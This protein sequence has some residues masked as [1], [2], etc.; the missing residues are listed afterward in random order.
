MP[1]PEKQAFSDTLNLSGIP[2]CAIAWFAP[3]APGFRRPMF[4]GGIAG[5]G[6]HAKA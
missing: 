5:V 3:R 4:E 6:R 1:A 2:L